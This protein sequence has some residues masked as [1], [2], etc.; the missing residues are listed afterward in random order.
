MKKI[1]IF[2][3][4]LIII[5]TNGFGFLETSPG[6]TQRLV[7]LN[8]DGTVDFTDYGLLTR[9][10][11]RNET[12]FDIA[13]A[14]GDG[15]VDWKELIVLADNWL[16]EYGEI[17][18]IQWLVHASVKIWT[19]DIVIYVDPAYLTESPNDADLILITHNHSDHY[20]PADIARVSG[21][22]TKIIAA[23]SVVTSHGSGQAILPGQ[24]IETDGVRI[25]AV[26]AYNINKTQHPKSNNWVGFIIEIGM[27]RIYCA[28]DTDLTDEMKALE[29]INV[30]FLPVSGTY[31]M[32]AAEAAEATGYFK[33]DLAIP[34]HWGRN[35][36]TLSDAQQFAELAQCRVKIMDTGEII[37]SDNWLD[38]APLIAYWKLDETEGDIALDSIGGINGI[39]YS[40]P[41]WQ[42]EGGKLD[43]A[44]EFDGIDDFA[45]TDFVMDPADGPFSIFAWIKTDTAGR[46]IISQ[47]NSSGTQRNWLSTNSPDGT[48]MTELKTA[49]RSGKSLTSEFSVTDDLWHHIGFVWD[50]SRRYLYA[51]GSEIAKDDSSITNLESFD[52]GLYFGSDAT[53]TD[54]FFAGLIDDIRIFGGAIQP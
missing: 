23:A 12:Q 25:T 3:F 53:G 51:D 24:T 7:D 52:G 16:T 30:A 43:G 40:G 13:P 42:P 26:H 29:D 17:V 28:G 6:V 1:V 4:A 49:G 48:L 44:L 8:L 14:I 50:G 20:S 21:P 9:F 5:Q 36:G 54:D 18:Y 34:Y 39:L 33:P 15:L 35:I 2:S 22:Q 47:A 38:D 32:N 41:I 37:S 45:M 31:A 27:Q 10:W 46:V 19:E 11:L